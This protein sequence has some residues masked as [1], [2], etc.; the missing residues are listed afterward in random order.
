M[1]NK[2]KFLLERFKS[3]EWSGPA[4]YKIEE[5]DKKTGFPELVSLVYFKPIHLGHGTETEIDGNKMGKLL[6]KVYKRF[7]DL[8]DCYLG[9]IHS[10]H[11]M[12]AFLSGKDKETAREQANGDGIFFS[13][14]VASS[15]KLYDCALAYKDRFGYTNLID[16]EVEVAEVTYDIPKEWKNEA[17]QI[18]KAKAKEK[19][20]FVGFNNQIS[21]ASNNFGYNYNRGTV[22]PKIETPEVNEAKKK[23]P[24]YSWDRQTDSSPKEEA[25]M[26]TLTQEFMDG[27]M[28]YHEFIEQ[29]SKDC[30]NT[31]PY[32]FMDSLGT[33]TAF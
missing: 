24:L 1:E 32:L 23:T 22:I 28:T 33:G 31:D 7:P 16:G 5:S 6:P 29:A 9:L 8:K 21:L 3:I 15:S 13:T 11:T 18:E 17:K 4:W 27:T 20:A 25:D 26:L 14:V 19:L 30:P 2:I 12:G 10:H